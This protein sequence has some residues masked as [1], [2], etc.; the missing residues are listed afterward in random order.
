MKSWKKLWALAIISTWIPLS[1]VI[2]YPALVW[3]ILLTLW[4]ATVL[5]IVIASIHRQN[6]REQRLVVQS[7]EQAAIKTLNH[8]RHDWMNDLQI[9]YGYM[10]LGKHDKTIDCVGRIK[11]RMY[12]EGK[13]AKL[14]IPSL[15]F[16]LQSFRTIGSN[17]ELE[18]NIADDLYLG[19]RMKPD[20]TQEWVS[21]IVESIRAFQY[22]ELSSWGETRKLTL[23]LY[24]EDGEVVAFFEGEGSHVDPEILQQ[25][26]HNVVR[27]H[28]VKA[29]QIYS[30]QGSFQLR[31]PCDT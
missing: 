6:E 5:W 30:T 2:W 12:L 25:Q 4:M 22:G 17:V 3:Y 21:A 9:L 19:G 18:V 14:G 20:D 24:E 11:E 13:I 28:Q 23:S 26:I 1:L 8:H 7:I 29:E 10:Q 31:V 27:S 15:V 16:Y